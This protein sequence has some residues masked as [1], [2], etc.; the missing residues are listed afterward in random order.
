[1]TETY[2]AAGS[3]VVQVTDA[4]LMLKYP[5]TINLDGDVTVA[6]LPVEG[7]IPDT[8]WFNGGETRYEWVAIALLY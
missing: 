4:T 2:G 6:L 5:E 7:D 3:I 8:S 1:M